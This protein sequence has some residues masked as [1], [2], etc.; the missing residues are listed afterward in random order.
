LMKE[1]SELVGRAKMIAT[2]SNAYVSYFS[3]RG[4]KSFKT[5]FK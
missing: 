3:F 4:F 5:T 1:D 2:N